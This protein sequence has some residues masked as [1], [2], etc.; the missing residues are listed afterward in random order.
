MQRSNKL[1]DADVHVSRVLKLLRKH[2]LYFSEC[3]DRSTGNSGKHDKI[4]DN[5]NKYTSIEEVSCRRVFKLPCLR[6]FLHK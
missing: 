1:G 5:T 6:C 2:I 4:K 3:A